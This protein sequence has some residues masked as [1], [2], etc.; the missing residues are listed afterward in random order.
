MIVKPWYNS[1]KMT[2]RERE[3]YNAFG[4]KLVGRRFMKVMV[5]RAVAKLPLNIINFLTKNCWF[6]SSMDDAW[7]F[8]F[9]GRDIKDHHLV[10]LSDELF[11]EDEAQIEYSI[12]HEIGHVVLNHRNSV[13]VS[14]TKEEIRH[15][16]K[17]ADEFAKKFTLY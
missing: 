14:Q 16:E 5:C 4:G 9:T 12:L 17:E 11:M 2:K 15:Q 3:I 13:L 6:V 1:L 8:A 10:F 7:G